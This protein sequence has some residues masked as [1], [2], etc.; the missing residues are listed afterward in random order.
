V[1]PPR[2]G[3]GARGGGGGE[4]VA[5]KGRRRR[6]TFLCS[7]P[8]TMWRAMPYWEVKG[9]EFWEEGRTRIER[10]AEGWQLLDK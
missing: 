5:S 6:V 1:G 9:L 2:A 10:E 7:G 8:S 3:G 4:G